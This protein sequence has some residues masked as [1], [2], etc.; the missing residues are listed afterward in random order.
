[1]VA[2]H[3]MYFYIEYLLRCPWEDQGRLASAE[4]SHHAVENLSLSLDACLVS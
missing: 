1:M 4:S 3:F 2:R